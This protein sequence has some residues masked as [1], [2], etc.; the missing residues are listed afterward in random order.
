MTVSVIIPAYN[1]EKY[2][3]EAVF[4]VHSAFGSGIIPYE[5]IVVDDGSADATSACL[6]GS[7]VNLVS[8]NNGGAASARNAGLKISS[9]DMIAFLDADDVYE[10]GALRLL[11]QN[12]VEQNA[13]A[14]F[15]KVMDFVS[16]ELLEVPGL[17][18]PVRKQP[19][20]GMLTGASL[21]RRQVFDEIGV[22]NENLPSGETVEW[23]MRLR[24]SGLR[25]VQLEQTVL[26]RRIHLSNTGRLQRTKEMKSY[27]AALRIRNKKK[28]DQGS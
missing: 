5:I 26:K 1:A 2:I 14:V 10:P 4:S 17:Q 27:A 6:T 21:I 19:Y 22:F 24:D 23:M 12:M 15:A 9:G 8:R 20:S 13:D 3:L 11:S 7:G 28:A 25:T 18:L 16:P